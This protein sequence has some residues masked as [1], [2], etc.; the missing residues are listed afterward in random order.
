MGGQMKQRNEAS[1][2]D[3][4]ADN[5]GVP[6]SND[7][8]VVMARWLQSTGLQH[9][10]SPVAANNGND[11]IHLPN[12]LMQAKLMRNLNFNGESGSEPF[13]PIAQGFGG[14]GA[15]D[16]YYSPDFQADFGAGLLDLHAMD[17]TELLTE[18]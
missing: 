15:S 18:V 7:G 4:P 16:G 6:A 5:A 9:L 14:I 2:Y 11:Q 13:S 17:D 8:D 3:Q 1:L 12:L 10:S